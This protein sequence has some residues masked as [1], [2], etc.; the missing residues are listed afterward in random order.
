[1]KRYFS[2]IL[3]LTGIIFS[4]TIVGTIIVKKYY[5]EYFPTHAFYQL[6]SWVFVSTE[7]NDFEGVETIHL[8]I[9]PETIRHFKEIYGKFEKGNVEFYQQNNIW[10]NARLYIGTDAGDLFTL[11]GTVLEPVANPAA[12]RINSILRFDGR[13]HVATESG[14]FRSRHGRFEQIEWDGPTESEPKT[15]PIASLL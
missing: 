12:G 7:R 14:V 13:L 3:F 9:T 11:E 6:K 5:P 1:M 2:K 15:E 8:K 10:H 4:L